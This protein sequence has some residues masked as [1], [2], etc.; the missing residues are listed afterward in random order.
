MNNYRGI[1][2]LPPIAKLLEQLLAKQIRNY[3]ESNKLFYA[4]QHGFRKGFYCELALHG[5]SEVGGQFAHRSLIFIT[6]YL[7]K[8]KFKKKIKV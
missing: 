6:F 7:R 3:F 2:I 1:S 5:Q 4:G 8:I